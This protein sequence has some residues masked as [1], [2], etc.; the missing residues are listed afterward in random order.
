MKNVY[1]TENFYSKSPMPF[2]WNRFYF[3]ALNNE[4]ANP[5]DNC[6]ILKTCS[7]SGTEI[8]YS[9]KQATLLSNMIQCTVYFFGDSTDKTGHH[10]IAEILLK[11]ALNS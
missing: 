3:S 6:I 9:Q 5:D 11:M 4:F 1:Q 2:V 10:N 8:R 7:K